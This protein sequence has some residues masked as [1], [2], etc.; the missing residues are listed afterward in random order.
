MSIQNLRY[1]LQIKKKKKFF[2]F[3]KFFFFPPLKGEMNTDEIDD[4]LVISFTQKTQIDIKTHFVKNRNHKV[5]LLSQL[6]VP[7]K[8]AE[9]FNMSQR[10][11]KIFLLKKL[12]K[13]KKIKKKNLGWLSSFGFDKLQIRIRIGNFLCRGASKIYF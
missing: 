3:S 5:F 9:A 13:L 12:K 10:R 1:K 4:H 11:V 2:K 8:L 7:S 6:F